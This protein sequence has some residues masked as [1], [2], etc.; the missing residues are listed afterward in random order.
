M[1]TNPGFPKAPFHL[2]PLL[3]RLPGQRVQAASSNA[4]VD[5]LAGFDPATGSLGVL[6]GNWV[7]EPDAQFATAVNL[8]LHCP[9]LAGRTVA[10][11][12][13]RVDRER[14]NA[15]DDWQRLGRP[16]IT[17][18]ELLDC[19]AGRRDT[20]RQDEVARLFETLAAAAQLEPGEE[21]PLVFTADGNAA[22]QIGL[23]VFGLAYLATH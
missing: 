12:L 6:L 5:V 18:A 19:L 4:P 9:A 8:R 13:I 7:E 3:D 17:S 11:R 2:Y 22:C 21:L 10:A 1:V 16:Q 20:P 14:S 23:P 15:F